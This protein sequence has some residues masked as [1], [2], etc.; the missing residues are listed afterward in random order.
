MNS[1]EKIKKR[2]NRPKNLVYYK[3][4]NLPIAFQFKNHSQ[5]KFNFM[6]A[7]S[8]DLESNN[9]LYENYDGEVISIDSEWTSTNSPICL[10]IFIA[11]YD[12]KL[13][14]LNKDLKD[15]N[16]SLY[17]QNVVSYGN[18]HTVCNGLYEFSFK[19]VDHSPL[20]FALQNYYTK[21][22]LKYPKKVLLL[23]HYSVKD[24]IHSFGP[25]AMINPMLNGNSRRNSIDWVDQSRNISGQITLQG[26]KFVLFDL[27][28]F[29][30]SSFKN[31]AETFGV[32]VESKDSMNPYKD[33]M[34]NAFFNKTKSIRNLFL[35]YS[36]SDAVDL[37][38]LWSARIEKHNQMLND[39]F[40]FSQNY[41]IPPERFP[42]TTGRL[43]A[44][45]FENFIS[46]TLDK[47]ID[48]NLYKLALYR[49]G[50][51]NTKHPKYTENVINRN[52]IFTK[53]VDKVERINLIKNNDLT[54]KHCNK[55]VYQFNAQNLASIQYFFTFDR[56]TFAAY[57]S[58]VAGG[59][60]VNEKPETLTFD[61]TLDADLTSCYGTALEKFTY[62]I[63]HPFM[64]NKS[65][66]QAG[67]TLRTFL[68]RYE[69]QLVPNCYQITVSGFLTFEQDLILSK[70]VSKQAISKNYQSYEK[71]DSY[72]K[73]V[74]TNL[75]LLR[76]QIENGIIT[77]EILEIIKKVGTNLEK[78]EFYELE[79]VSALF[80][81]KDLQKKNA[82][83]WS[84]ACLDTDLKLGSPNFWFSIDLK[85]FIS[86]LIQKRR[87]YQSEY[88]KTKNSQDNA[89]QAS[90]KLIINTLYGCIASTFFSI[91]NVCVA[92]NITSFARANMWLMTKAL[93]GHQ[94]ITDGCVFS[95]EDVLFHN[96]GKIRL[97]GFA[98]LSNSNK[99]SKQRYIST[100]SL[101]KENW[102][103]FY[104]NYNYFN[105]ID[106]NKLIV[107]HINY[108]CSKYKLKL[109]LN[110]ELKMD[111]TAL[112]SAHWG[113]AH[114]SLLTYD[115]ATQTFSNK[116]YWIRG[117]KEFTNNKRDP[118]FTILENFID[119]NF[120]IP[121]DLTYYSGGLLKIRE[122]RKKVKLD[123]TYSLL[124]GDS[125]PFT[126]N[127]LSLSFNFNHFKLLTLDE[128]KNVSLNKKKYQNFTNFLD[129]YKEM[130]IDFQLIRSKILKN[131]TN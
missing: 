39:T 85:D 11:K 35:R 82:K 34:E 68:Y 51:L 13:I 7:I 86:P 121:S 67:L 70:S 75:I 26:T 120:D 131:L 23:F 111:N 64:Y 71:E 95:P 79:V 57:S 24:L 3:K 118:L 53:A 80:Y 55:K 29:I 94:S 50:Y 31:C 105:G 38:K 16:P 96:Q 47:Q 10:Q 108:F 18:N 78:K 119:G 112:K 44:D 5:V 84:E 100:G 45:T 12:A 48:P 109:K 124:P 69:E 21:K 62:P 66:N 49:A 63:G 87:F 41:L 129:L 92:N 97:P 37:Y 54:N 83:E 116:K 125:K 59:R 56:K 117:H 126:T 123:N 72:G 91:G 6:D 22:N 36:I 20:I 90:L 58:L 99:F 76:R 102:K 122:W 113:K 130:E 98:I 17:Y 43:I 28:G 27:Y 114:Y 115:K 46:F 73:S 25:D 89:N 2:K 81:P 128:S 127:T 33:C 107:D 19:K 30:N 106:V 52:E 93:N 77:T 101:G 1:I 110:V 103:D 8:E 65:I 40:G 61:R 60:T 74:D 9:V 15:I 88:K 14:V 42:A 32:I 104:T 4:P